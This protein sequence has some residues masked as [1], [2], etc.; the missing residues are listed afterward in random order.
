M[1]KK[2]GFNAVVDIN[3]YFNSRQSVCNA[4]RDCSKY[5]IKHWYNCQLH[6]CQLLTNISFFVFNFFYEKSTTFETFCFDKSSGIK[7]NS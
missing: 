7:S 6:Y 5:T 2:R 1:K 4:L 3:S